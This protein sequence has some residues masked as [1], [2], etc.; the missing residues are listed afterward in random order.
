MLRWAM[1]LSRWI[2]NGGAAGNGA[3]VGR[4]LS[5][6]QG[7]QAHV[8]PPTST[9]A[10]G[11]SAI[12]HVIFTMRSAPGGEVVD[13]APR[14]SGRFPGRVGRARGRRAIGRAEL[15]GVAELEAREMGDQ[16]PNVNLIAGGGSA[17]AHA[18]VYV[19]VLAAAR[20]LVRGIVGVRQGWDGVIGA[21]D[22]DVGAVG[23]PAAGGDGPVVGEVLADDDVRGQGSVAD[24]D[25]GGVDVDAAVAVPLAELATPSPSLSTHWPM[26]LALRRVDAHGRGA[27]ELR[28]STQLRAGLTERTSAAAPA[29]VGEEWLVPPKVA[30]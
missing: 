22:P 6:R 26:A 1:L 25:H 2:S 16:G 24:G 14:R 21:A 12:G 11:M 18:A 5:S 9:V 3:V 15:L 19:V 23:V 29:T 28:T 20:A 8:A 27:E 17:V 30:A 10:G 4:G 7:C 13:A